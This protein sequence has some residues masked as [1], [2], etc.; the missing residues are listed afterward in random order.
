MELTKEVSKNNFSGYLWHAGFSALAINFMDI[1]TVIP[2]MLLKAG[3]S[4]IHLGLMTALLMGGASLMRLVFA[5]L[6]SNFPHKKG[7]LLWGINLRVLSLAGIGILLLF[8]AMFAKSMTILMIFMI[9]IVF[10]FSGAFAVIS[11]MDILGKS[12]LPERRK[13]F[14]SIRYAINGVLYF[15]SAVAVKKLITLYNFPVNYSILFFIAGGLLLISSGGFWI[16]KEPETVIKKKKSFS[17]FLKMIPSEIK[18]NKNLLNYLAII[19]TIGLGLGLMPFLVLLAK[20]NYGLTREMIGSFLLF[21]TVGIVP[22][23]LILLKLSKK[24]RYKTTLIISL[25]IGAL[26]PVIALLLGNFPGYFKYL[27]IFSGI[28][29][30]TFRISVE[31]LLIEISTNENRAT[32]TGISG[33]GRILPT[34]FPLFAGV[35]ISLWGYTVVFSMV[36]L[37]ILMGLIFVLRM[38][39]NEN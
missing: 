14:F 25:V 10:S 11:Y 2:A 4:A 16:I 32:Y 33:S 38:D 15:L 20:E 6:V 23:G 30:T 9:M 26:L 22:T 31:G 29:V 35:L 37:F 7:F 19:N 36:S 12:I 3:G 34:L 27:F 39:V 28:F 17:E 5:G 18:K 13:K 8:S 24:F 1:D 21:K